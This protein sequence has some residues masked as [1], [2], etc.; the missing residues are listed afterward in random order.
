MKLLIRLIT[1]FN[2]LLLFSCGQKDMALNKNNLDPNVKPGTNFYQYANGGWIKNNP[3][4]PEF[5][6]YGSFD[7]LAENT[8]TMLREVVE[9]IKL[10]NTQAG[11]VAE[12]TAVF[13]KTGMDTA[14]IE[15]DGIKPLLAELNLINSANDLFQLQNVIARWHSNGSGLLFKF[16]SSPDRVNSEMVIANIYQGGIGLTDVDYYISK[17]KNSENILNEYRKYISKMHILAGYSHSDAEVKASKI[18]QIETRL[19]QASMSRLE[20]RDPHKT[21]NKMSLAELNKRIPEFNWTGFLQIT[22]APSFDEL[23]VGQ[24]L[25]F[26][27]INNMMKEVP[28]ED[29]KTYLAWHVI[30]MSAEYLSFEFVIANFEFYGKFLSGKREIQPRWKRIIKSADNAMGEALGKLYTEKHFP[31]AAKDRM[32]KLVDNLKFAMSERIT[33]LEWMSEATKKEALQKLKKINVKIGYP[34]VWRD[35]SE[36]EISDDSYFNNILRAARFNFNYNIQKIGKP[37]DPNEWGMTPQTVNAYYSPVRNEIVFPAGILQPPF[38]NMEADDAVNY[39][40]IGMVIGHEMTHGFDDKGR[41]YDKDGNLKDWWTNEDAERFMKRSEVLIAQYD[42]FI[43]HEDI[44]ANGKLTLGENIADLGGLNIAFTALKKAWKEN[45]PQKK[46]NGFTPEQRFFLAYAH[47]WAQNITDAEIIRRTKEDVHSLGK[48]RVNGPLPNMP[49]FY[50][51]FNISEDE[52][53]YLKPE[54][55]ALIW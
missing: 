20:M 8:L 32:I 3:L 50:Q 11:S 42:N 52:P 38:F 18:I 6:R 44:K 31:P 14:S 4:P 30:N 28:L 34:D 23:N 26:D 24:P 21:F 7:V 17:D 15:K 47:V 5:S 10:D 53:M 49:E 40:A 36:L 19:A 43:V 46:V 9:G 39:G 13:Y 29:W 51:A 41:M 2:L 35:Y 12:K 55:R 1:I 54:Q 45:P 48:F 25:F 33:A 27:E 16:F 37:V 22:G